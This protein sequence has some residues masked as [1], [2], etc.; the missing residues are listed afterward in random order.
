M[1]R[2]TGSGRLNEKQLRFVRKVAARG[3]KHPEKRK[4]YVALLVLLLL[5]FYLISFLGKH[6]A[7]ALCGGLLSVLVLCLA[8]SGG[9]V[10]EK[11]HGYREAM[12][13]QQEQLR[14]LRD[15]IM[16]ESGQREPEKAFIQALMEEN[17]DTVA[18]LTVPGTNIDY[19]VMQTP[20]NEDYYLYRDFY[21]NKD[22]NGSLIL[23]VGCDTA[24]ESTNWIIH[25]H[26][27]K[28]GAMFGG[29]MAY[30]EK[31][32]LEE[33]SR[34]VLDTLEGKKVYEIIAVFKSEV[35]YEN[36]KVFKY[37]QCYDIANKEDFDY[38]YEN[39]K[40]LSL[41]DTDVTAEYGDRFLTLSTC[42]YHTENGRF[43]VVGKE[44]YK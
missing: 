32:Y 25:G 14:N 3:K 20:E 37:Y 29:L 7:A 30:Q 33:H 5:W 36:D 38:F 2:K 26:N 17:E 21:K 15:K 4:L 1:E 18:W 22:K 31:D 28:S 40:A 24:R 23:A 42:A 27:M 12:T 13:R 10:R 41:Y 43:V 6:R 8:I 44:V 34:M 39:I 19:P 16:E 11:A 35:F 9:R